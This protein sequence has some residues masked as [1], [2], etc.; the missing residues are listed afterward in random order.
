MT[1][2]KDTLYLL[3]ARLEKKMKELRKRK[4]TAWQAPNEKRR[5]DG[6]PFAHLLENLFKHREDAQGPPS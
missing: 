1:E 5:R 4:D 6:H 3:S 2:T